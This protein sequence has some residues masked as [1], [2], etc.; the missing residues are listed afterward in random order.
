MRGMNP[1]KVYSCATRVQAD[2]VAAA[3][4]SASSA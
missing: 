1:V 3:L 2:L 4:N